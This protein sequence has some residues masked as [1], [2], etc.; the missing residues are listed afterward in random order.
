MVKC[1]K[2]CY[3]LQATTEEEEYLVT[4]IISHSRHNL[5]EINPFLFI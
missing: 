3:S 2:Q 1:Y 4:Y 5:E